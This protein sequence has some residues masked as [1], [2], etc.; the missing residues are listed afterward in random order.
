MIQ[1]FNLNSGCIQT[2][3]ENCNISLWL[4]RSTKS[5]L[6]TYCRRSCS[7]PNLIIMVRY[8]NSLI[9]K[10]W[11]NS[12]ILIRK[13]TF[14]LHLEVNWVR[15]KDR[16]Y[17]WMIYAIYFQYLK[18]GQMKSNRRAWLAFSSSKLVIRCFTI[19]IT[20][21]NF[22][23]GHWARSSLREYIW[24]ILRNSISRQAKRDRTRKKLISVMLK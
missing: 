19:V 12:S 16:C 9:M 21:M 10:S 11:Y 24:P 2:Q 14:A 4:V 13:K 20:F 17:M 8:Q 1:V 15:F 6:K 3:K 18:W 7:W 5:Q 23:W 22:N